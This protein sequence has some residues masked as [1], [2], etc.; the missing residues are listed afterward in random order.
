MRIRYVWVADS[1]VRRTTS[2]V[3]NPQVS[4][5][6]S[7]KPVKRLAHWL[8]SRIQFPAPGAYTSLGWHELSTHICKDQ[9]N[10]PSFRD[11]KII[12]SLGLGSYHAL[13]G[14]WIS[15]VCTARDVTVSQ[16]WCKTTIL[17]YWMVIN[18]Y[19]MGGKESVD[20]EFQGCM[21]LHC[22]TEYYSVALHCITEY[23]VTGK[24]WTLNFV[25]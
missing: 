15:L 13:V 5:A 14:W 6:G 24:G 7:R 2:H 9:I 11:R 1:L 22:I 3:E 19:Y 10:L 18:D 25:C 20:F 23:V 17:V 8:A 16:R 4:Y 12:N 21:V